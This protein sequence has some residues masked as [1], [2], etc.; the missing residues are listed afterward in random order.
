MINCVFINPVWLR[1]PAIISMKFEIVC[2]SS[3]DLSEEYAERSHLNVVPFYVSLDG[4]KYFREG[5]E[6]SIAEFY[7]AMVDHGDWYPKTSMPSIQDY[8]D[9]FLPIVEKGMPILCI[10]ITKKFS[11]S[12]QSALNARMLIEEEHP[13]AKIYVMDSKLVTALQGLFV[14]EAIR[15]RDMDLELEKAVQLLEDIRSTGRIFFTTKD[16]KYLRN[17]GR[18]GKAACI[19]GS[20]LN[21]KPV[22]FFSDGEL[23]PAEVCRGRK[24]SIQRIIDRFFEYIEKEKI[25]L[26]EYI[27]A[28]GIGLDNPD[29]EPFIKALEKRF[30]ETGIHPANW[31]K[32]HIGA[33]IGVHTGPYPMGLGILKKCPIE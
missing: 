23:G 10:C 24:K 14:E 13:D 26:S 6:I 33:T 12:M 28:T 21:L 17:G 16:L 5:K 11:G 25:K 3:A 2:D 15:L 1:V 4:E 7:Q 18:I 31:S 27:F 22:L 30:E 8:V 19:A 29:Y 20:V 9:A 32:M